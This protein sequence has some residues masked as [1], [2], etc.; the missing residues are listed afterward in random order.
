MKRLLT[1]AV[2][3]SMASACAPVMCWEDDKDYAV[4]THMLGWC[5]GD[6]GPYSSFC[7]CLTRYLMQRR[8]C[9]AIQADGIPGED[10]TEACSACG[11][12][13]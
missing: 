3:L 7:H 6:A 13:C 9:D 12:S 4:E 2:L 8:T 5:Q 10:V 11:G 1:L